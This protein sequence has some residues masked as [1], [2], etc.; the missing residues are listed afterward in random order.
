MNPIVICQ[1]PVEGIIE[2]PLHN[3]CQCH[4]GLI[5][6]SLPS[7]TMIDERIREIYVSCDQIDAT[8]NNRKRL[9]R[10]FGYNSSLTWSTY[11]FATILYFKIDSSEKKLTF[12]F[13]DTDGPLV[14]LNNQYNSDKFIV[15]LNMIPAT[16]NKSYK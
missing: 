13:Y 2:I 12:R 3:S 15:E 14:P 9:L 11:N 1:S 5:S 10:V 7:L 6:I 16:T 4:I 8:L